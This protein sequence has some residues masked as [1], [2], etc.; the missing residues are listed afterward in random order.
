MISIKMV[1]VIATLTGLLLGVLSI[2]VSV[3]N[4]KRFSEIC[5]LYK[6][7]YGS[8]PDAVLLFENVNTLY[9]NI[10]YSTKV[11]FIY[12]PLLWNRSSILTKNDDK[13]FIRGLP[14]RLIG[15][16]YVEIFLAVVSLIF[17]IIGGL[18]MVAIERGWV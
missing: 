13:D 11:Q 9:I 3:L 12:I 2:V 5:I 8:L 10:A 4:R 16:F 14:K 18:L 15:P 17:F 1:S 6:K 7:K